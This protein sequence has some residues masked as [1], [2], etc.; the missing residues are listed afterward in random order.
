MTH[1]KSTHFSEFD[2]QVLQQTL[3]DFYTDNNTDNKSKLWNFTTASGLVVLLISLVFI[4]QMILG[5]F[6]LN[7]NLVSNSFMEALS[8]IGGGAVIV[9][10]LGW[11]RRKGKKKKL[12]RAE[13][14]ALKEHRNTYQDSSSFQSSS[15]ASEKTYS[16][17]SFGQASRTA[18][19][20]SQSKN[21]IYSDQNTPESY[22]LAKNNR[23]FRSRRDKVL[24]G[25]LGGL[26][27]YVGISPA[28]LRLIFVIGLFA[29]AGAP[30]IFGYI[31]ATF[32]IPKEPQRDFRFFEPRV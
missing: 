7:L 5:V 24:S 1:S 17:S 21:R 15:Q 28:I 8:V 3:E 27:K 23:L 4:S 13:R 2:E 11:F 12:S 26:A 25:V 22:G 16:S 18:S 31:I 32:I 20:N 29:S 19:F 6:G 30:F 10:G 9:T 14:K